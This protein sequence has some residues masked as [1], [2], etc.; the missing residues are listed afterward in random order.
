[1]KLLLHLLALLLVTTAA[2]SQSLY[3][4]PLTGTAWDT[5]SVDS[6]GWCRPQLDTLLDYVGS[7][8]SKAFIL[9]KDGKIVAERYYGT[10]TRDSAWYWASAGKTI[11]A[12][13]TGLA[14]QEG[15]LSLSDTTAQYL[16][17]GWTVC[18]T[19]KE[20]LI[21]I[22][23][24]LTMTTGLN[25]SVPDHFCTLDTCL[26]YKADAGTRWAYHNGPY[27]L[28]D[29]VIESA[30][31]TTL[32]AYFNTRV[33]SLTGIT[34]IFLPSGFNN[35]Y[36]ST[37]RSMARFGLLML[38]RGKWN[39]TTIMT[40]T[41]YFSQMVNTSQTLHSSYGY[42]WW[43]NGKSS[44]MVPGLQVVFPGPLNPS[45]PPDMI[46]ALGKNGQLINISES[47]KLVWIR[48]GDAPGVG[49]VPI[50]FNDT[51]WQH[52]NK[53]MCDPVAVQP[54][55]ITQ[56]GIEVYP[57]PATSQ[58]NIRMALAGFSYLLTDWLGR[59]VAHG[60]SQASQIMV[61]VADLASGCYILTVRATDGAVTK[62]KVL[63][64]R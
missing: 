57:L 62:T 19:A 1:M 33:K 17:T 6:L 48:M 54:T 63:V 22:R 13:V 2:R 32:N 38:G 7:K 5:T 53:V 40:D 28:L 39:T 9:L 60:Q 27:T 59:E 41:A 50:L 44:F 61:N 64:G 3:Y 47:K 34:G 51:I 58:F 31:G 52:L 25:D 56:P 35:V 36:Y 46:A 16:G 29:S 55:T 23:H 20:N 12:F 18:P 45:A 37:A 10:F 24:Q 8:N 21:T 49:E 30:T 42:L 26:Q 43:L 14:Q 4:P 15:H 11:T